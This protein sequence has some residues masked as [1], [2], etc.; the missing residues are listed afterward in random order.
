MERARDKMRQLILSKVEDFVKMISYL[1]NA[2]TQINRLESRL[3]AKLLKYHDLYNGAVSINPS[4]LG[5]IKTKSNFDSGL[6]NLVNPMADVRTECEALK[7]EILKI[8][9]ETNKKIVEHVSDARMQ[10]ILHQ[11]YVLCL[12]WDEI[13]AQ[14]WNDRT[15]MMGVC[16]NTAHKL[17]RQALNEFNANFEQ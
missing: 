6:D 2:S 1:K 5:K 7:A 4:E 17:H 15:G 11:R 3:S 9:I 13:A 10:E 12:S 8:S 16:A 14:I